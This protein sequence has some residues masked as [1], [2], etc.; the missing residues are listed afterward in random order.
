VVKAEFSVSLFQ[1][2]VSHDPSENHSNMLVWCSSNISY[3]CFY[4]Y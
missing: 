2:S 3:Y 1:S 4:Y